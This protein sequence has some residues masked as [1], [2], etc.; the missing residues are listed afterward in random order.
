[1]IVPVEMA[2]EGA[3]TVSSGAELGTDKVDV[4]VSVNVVVVD[5]DDVEEISVECLTSVVVERTIDSGTV[6]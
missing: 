5:V 6:D 2:S 4:L 3:S 1:M